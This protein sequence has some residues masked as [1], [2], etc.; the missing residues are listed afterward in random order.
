MNGGV[1]L[2]ISIVC[3]KKNAKVIMKCGNTSLISVGLVTWVRQVNLEIN[4]LTV[5]VEG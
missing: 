1:D 5:V 2:N 4:S 3:L